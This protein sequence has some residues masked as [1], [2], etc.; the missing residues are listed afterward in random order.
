MGGRV[1]HGLAFVVGGG[2][3]LLSTNYNGTDGDLS[4]LGGSL[5]L[6]KGEAHQGQVS[7]PLLGGSRV[8]SSRAAGFVV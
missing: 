1:S 4:F 8:I 6:F 5:G 2:K 3:Y 7:Y